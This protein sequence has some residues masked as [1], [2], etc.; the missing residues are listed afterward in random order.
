MKP[1]SVSTLNYPRTNRF[2]A[3]SRRQLRYFFSVVFLPLHTIFYFRPDQTLN[4]PLASCQFVRVRCGVGS[5]L[6]TATP[7]TYM[8]RNVLRTKTF[9]RK[10]ETLRTE[11][12]RC[13]DAAVCGFGA[14]LKE[15]ESENASHR[16]QTKRT[17]AKSVLLYITICVL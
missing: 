4:P 17:P 15:T 12:R 16:K 6:C 10:L 1:L 9:N 3:P 7:G 13:G 5:Y 11:E 8:L 14:E 2:L